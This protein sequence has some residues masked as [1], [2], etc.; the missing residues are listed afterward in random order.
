MKSF[1][2]HF[3]ICMRTTTN[4][5]RERFSVSQINIYATCPDVIFSF[6]ASQFQSDMVIT[7]IRVDELTL[8]KGTTSFATCNFVF[9]PQMLIYYSKPSKQFCFEISTHV[10]TD[11]SYKSSIMQTLFLY[12]Y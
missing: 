10:H 9:Q 8:K 6:E 11:T 7:D 1:Q 2:E 3:P 5:A 4:G 12:L